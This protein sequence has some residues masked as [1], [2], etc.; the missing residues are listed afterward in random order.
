MNYGGDPKM[1]KTKCIRIYLLFLFFIISFTNVFAELEK[2]I[3]VAIISI[4]SFNVT[5]ADIFSDD[6]GTLICT[7]TQQSGSNVIISVVLS[8]TISHNLLPDN[9]IQWTNGTSGDN[10]FER[11]VSREIAGS[12]ITVNATIGDNTKGVRI[13]VRPVEIN[14]TAVTPTEEV[15]EN[16]NAQ[17]ANC[18]PQDPELEWNVFSVGNDWYVRI[19]SMTCKGTINIPSWPNLPNMM[20]V[21]NTPNPSDGGNISNT[22]GSLNRWEYAI[23]DLEDY[24]EINGGR[25][26]HWHDTEA[27]S[28][29]EWFHWNTDWMDLSINGNTGGNWPTTENDL[30]DFN[31]SVFDYLTESDAKNALSANVESRFDTF[32]NAAF[33]RWIAE[34][35]DPGMSC[36]AYAA[37][38]NVL[39]G[40]IQNIETYRQNKGWQ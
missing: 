33:Q 35:D 23:S 38:Q 24:D 25:G 2:T 40:H 17:G 16:T 9:S 22:N 19:D 4:D 28:A 32:I 1:Y 13:Y 15:T 5:N 10:Q 12:D 30:E 29:H 21:P 20:T 11:I 14:N 3:N 8:P 31:V 26:P 7:T 18:T 6:S 34:C 27:S 37:G 36:G 39:D